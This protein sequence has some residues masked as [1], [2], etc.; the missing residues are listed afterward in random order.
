MSPIDPPTV[1]VV[2]AV[3][4]R[5]GGYLVCQRPSA[6]RHGGLWEF[7]GGKVHEGETLGQAVRRELREELEME[8]LEVAAEPR[9]AAPDPDSHF[10]IL[11]LETVAEGEPVAHEH[12]ALGWY[13]VEELAGLPLAPSDLR[14]VREVLL[15]E[16]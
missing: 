13:P 12:D 8:A 10:V 11:F 5:D 3:I 7:P 9:F 16:Q 15:R 6:K 2:A 4:R 14:F 1:P